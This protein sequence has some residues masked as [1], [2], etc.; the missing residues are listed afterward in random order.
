MSIGVAVLGSTG[1]V[2]CS[3]LDV[4]WLNRERFRVAVLAAAS[5]VELLLAQCL[6]FTPEWAALESPDAARELERRLQAQ[7]AAR[8]SPP[9][10]LRSRS[11][12]PTPRSI[13]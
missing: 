4:L 10:P 8:A 9:A 6:R 7:A 2:G 1:S 13:T 12:R 11:S 5:N 3:T